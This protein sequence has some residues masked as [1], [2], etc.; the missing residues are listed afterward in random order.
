VAFEALS[1]TTR[2]FFYA[3]AR[4]LLVSYWPVNSGAAVKLT[5]IAFEEMRK[6]EAAGAPICRVEALRRAM[7]ALIDRGSARE[8]HPSTWAPFVVVGEGGARK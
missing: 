3:G 5:T 1:G 7:L 4:A 6:S 2:A 8:A